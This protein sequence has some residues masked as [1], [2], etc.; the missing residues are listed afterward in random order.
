MS[1]GSRRIDLAAAT[2]G[3]RLALDVCDGAGR[4]LIAAGTELSESSLA[5]LRQ[6]GISQLHI[7]VPVS[8][9][10]LEVRRQ[11]VVQRLGHLFRRARG[12]PLMDRLYDA[13]LAYRLE[14]LR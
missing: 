5:S 11:A 14:Q 2:A 9:A 13:V 1:A 8:E 4:V 12:N 6:R 7:E 10:E 3:V